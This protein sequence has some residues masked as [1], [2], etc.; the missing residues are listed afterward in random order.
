MKIFVMSEEDSLKLPQQEG[1]SQLT[2]FGNK[3]ELLF[4]T[5]NVML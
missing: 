2:I 5:K 1:A 4:K 3:T